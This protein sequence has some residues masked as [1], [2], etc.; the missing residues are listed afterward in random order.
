MKTRIN[1][2]PSVKGLTGSA[3]NISSVLE[4]NIIVMDTCPGL[5][6][7]GMLGYV[8]INKYSAHR[9]DVNCCS[10]PNNVKISSVLLV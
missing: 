2:T 7:Y 3:V 6:C 5:Q 1:A 8:D 4:K 9:C 10:K